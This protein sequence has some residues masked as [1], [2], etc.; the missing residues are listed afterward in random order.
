MHPLLMMQQNG[1]VAQAL[2]LPRWHSCQR[3]KKTVDS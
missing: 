2:C 1:P 3:Q